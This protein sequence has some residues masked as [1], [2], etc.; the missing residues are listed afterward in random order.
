[1]T[2]TV[3]FDGYAIPSDLIALT[4][5]TAETFGQHAEGQ[6]AEMHSKIGLEPGHAVL[7]IGCGVGRSSI[8]LT[9]VLTRGRYLGIDIIKPSIDWASSNISKRNPNFQFEHFDVRDDLHNPDGTI[10]PTN[11][12]IPAPDACF[13]RIIAWSV[14]THLYAEEIENYL[15]E[16][17]R[18]LKPNGRIWATCFVIT[19]AV[20]RSAQ[21]T[22][23]TSWDLRFENE[24]RNGCYINIKSVPRGAIGYSPERLQEMVEKAGLRF[25]KPFVGG[26]WSGYYA[27]PESGQDGMILTR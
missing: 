16:F 18:V 1:M 19:P 17:H 11:V 7:E 15:R 5:G 14:F 20:L 10:E 9:R 24:P 27:V 3:S 6:L 25:V 4:G 26:H 21:R 23:G 2:E 22:N 13:D 12:K 8:P